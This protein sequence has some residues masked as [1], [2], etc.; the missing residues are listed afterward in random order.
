MDAH[1]Q[2]EVPVLIRAL[3][4]LLIVSFLFPPC[5]LAE[6]GF[7]RWSVFGGAGPALF[8]INQNST[9]QARPIM[10]IE[11][12]FPVGLTFG[13]HFAYVEAPFGPGRVYQTSVGFR[14]GWWVLERLQLVAR[15]DYVS[16]R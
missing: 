6:E 3:S 9:V 7:R 15:Y 8:R 4:L 12:A 10:G 14:F 5:A 1:R 13:N 11:I 16:T 2:P